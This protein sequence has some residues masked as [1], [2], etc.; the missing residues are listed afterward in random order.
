MRYIKIN[1]HVGTS[2]K[3]TEYQKSS[4]V[5]KATGEKHIFSTKG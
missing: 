4:G 3:T 5:L 2:Y 1:L